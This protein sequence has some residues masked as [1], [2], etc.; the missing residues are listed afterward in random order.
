L[1]EGK[2]MKKSVVLV[3]SYFSG[4][5]APIRIINLDCKPTTIYK[6][7]KVARAEAIDD[8]GEV[9][10][11]DKS[12]CSNYTDPEWNKILDSVL[13]KVSYS[14]PEYKLAK[15]CALLT[16]YSHVFATKSGNLGQTDLLTHRIETRRNP[17]RQAVRRAPLPKREEVKNLL[18]EMQE[19]GITTSSKSPW[20]SP[21]V[22]VPKKD[23][24]LRFCV[25]Y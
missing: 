3:A 25:D 18:A 10:S 14:F 7:T 15:L 8:V 24:S 1:V 4:G 22:L 2:P 9:L 5:F 13:S 6:D 19:K 11:V 12:H 23:G 17:V 20:A 16:S 21:I